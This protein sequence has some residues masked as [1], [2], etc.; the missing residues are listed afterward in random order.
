[1]LVNLVS[2]ISTN[3]PLQREKQKVFESFYQPKEYG[4]GKENIYS[5]K[6]LWLHYRKCYRDINNIVLIFP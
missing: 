5:T 6:E 1:M 2:I 3:M 4:G